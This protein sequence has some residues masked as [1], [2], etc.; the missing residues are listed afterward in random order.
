MNTGSKISLILFAFCLNGVVYAQTK[1][2][3]PSRVLSSKQ[4][5]SSSTNDDTY[6]LFPKGFLKKYDD[7]LPKDCSYL[8]SIG[9]NFNGLGCTKHPAILRTGVYQDPKDN[10]KGLVVHNSWFVCQKSAAGSNS[11]SNGDKGYAVIEVDDSETQINSAYGKKMALAFI[12]VN[13]D[14]AYDKSKDVTKQARVTIY[15]TDGDGWPYLS[16]RL[17]VF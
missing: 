12:A 5:S 10:S 8:H 2:T 11:C 1:I 13:D 16:S 7:E 15:A 6:P 17:K 3:E 14:Y 4:A 9:Y